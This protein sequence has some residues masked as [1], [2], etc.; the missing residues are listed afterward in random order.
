VDGAFWGAYSVHAADVD[1]D[2]DVDVLG[3]GEGADAIA[4]WE[5]TAG[6]GIAWTERTVDGAFWGAYSVHAADVDGDGDVDVLG[7]A[8]HADAITWWE[9]RLHRRDHH[10]SRAFRRLYG[11]VG[12]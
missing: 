12:R 3:A 2:G 4:W 11:G 1:G 7:A 6:D 5:N 10:G 9:E 8:L